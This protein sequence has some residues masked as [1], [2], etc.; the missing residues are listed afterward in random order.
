MRV[1]V[2]VWKFFVDIFWEDKNMLRY[3]YRM[4]V[5]SLEGNFGDSRE[6]FFIRAVVVLVFL[7]A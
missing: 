1:L 6:I 3:F 5:S 4:S 2:V 7:V